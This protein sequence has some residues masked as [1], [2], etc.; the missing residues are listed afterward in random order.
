M[1]VSLTVHQSLSAASFSRSPRS[2]YGEWLL[3]L[4]IY[5]YHWSLYT[6]LQWKPMSSR[7]LVQCPNCYATFQVFV[8]RLSTRCEVSGCLCRWTITVPCVSQWKKSRNA[9]C[10]WGITGRCILLLCPWLATRVLWCT[11]LYAYLWNCCSKLHIFM[12]PII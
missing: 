12:L 3:M 7:P 5:E 4:M 10:C 2:A 8:A 1:V 11:C 6:C 9:V